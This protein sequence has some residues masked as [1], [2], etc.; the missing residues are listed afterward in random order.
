MRIRRRVTIS[1]KSPV[2]RSVTTSSVKDGGVRAD[3]ARWAANGS[4]AP[5]GITSARAV[6]ARN[7]DENS[8]RDWILCDLRRCNC[9]IWRALDHAPPKASLQV[10]VGVEAQRLEL[11][12]PR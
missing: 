11:R 1:P 8:M 12:E 10:A 4:A 7:M 6:S 9:G 5:E 2:Q 3:V